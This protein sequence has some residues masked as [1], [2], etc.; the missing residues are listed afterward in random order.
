MDAL[1]TRG[2]PGLE[3]VTLI[4]SLVLA[5]SLAVVGEGNLMT[6]EDTIRVILE[7][8]WGVTESLWL[9]LL[10]WE[11]KL[12]RDLKILQSSRVKELTSNVL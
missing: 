8:I 4:S 5:P 2:I 12:G 1:N 9:G 10:I 7:I 3:R 11:L 6:S